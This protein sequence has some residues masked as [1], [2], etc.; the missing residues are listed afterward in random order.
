[1]RID[2]ITG[3]RAEF[4]ILKPLVIELQDSSKFDVRLLVTGIHLI[5]D[6]GQTAGEVESPLQKEIRRVSHVVV[7]NSP[8]C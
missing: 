1:M 5:H 7:R 8:C 6:F 3:T 2:V 4:G